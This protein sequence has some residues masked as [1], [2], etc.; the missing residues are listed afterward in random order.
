MTILSS[1]SS[2]QVGL[3]PFYDRDAKQALVHVSP[4]G[5][6]L[7]AMLSASRVLVVQ[8][9]ERAIS[10][11]NEDLRDITLDVQLGSLQGPSV[12]LAF[13]NGRAAVATVCILLYSASQYSRSCH[14]AGPWDLHPPPLRTSVSFRFS[15]TSTHNI[16]RSILWRSRT[17]TLNLMSPND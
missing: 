10:R 4:D 2:K 17:F 8:G 14:D 11:P 5:K 7:V 6:D 3:L 12:Y 9:W 13:E 1:T 16:P 15:S